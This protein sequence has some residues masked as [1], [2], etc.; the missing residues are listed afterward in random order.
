MPHNAQAQNPK[1]LPRLS[2]AVRD[3]E[4]TEDFRLIFASPIKSVLHTVF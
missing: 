1:W 4:S 2:T 3:V